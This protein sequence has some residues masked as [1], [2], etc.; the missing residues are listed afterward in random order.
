MAAAQLWEIKNG[1]EEKGKGGRGGR[2]ERGRE[3]RE[4]RGGRKDGEREDNY[5]YI[6]QFKGKKNYLVIIMHS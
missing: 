4:V 5:V 2:G 6:I 3:S 1:G